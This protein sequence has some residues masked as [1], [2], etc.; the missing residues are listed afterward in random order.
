MDLSCRFN[1]DVNVD[2]KTGWALRL[3]DFM[4]KVINYTKSEIFYC[5]YPNANSALRHYTI[6]IL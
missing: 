6:V 3:I 5:Q 4:K 2:L 1:A